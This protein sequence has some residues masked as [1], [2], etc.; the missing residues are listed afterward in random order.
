MSRLKRTEWVTIVAIIILLLALLPGGEWGHRRFKR[1]ILCR[2]VHIEHHYCGFTWEEDR[3]NACTEWFRRNV[4]ASHEHLWVGCST[5][6]SLQNLFGQNIGCASNLDYRPAELLTP[7]Q[8]LAVYEHIGN[9]NDSTQVFVEIRD[10]VLK[11]HPKGHCLASY[12]RDWVELDRF[13]TPWPEWSQKMDREIE[14]W[15]KQIEER[16]EN[17]K[18]RDRE[19]KPQ[20]EL[21]V[22]P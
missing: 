16:I 7:E 2:V 15:L 8:Q 14:E 6:Y 12:L 4:A 21:L 11:R 17:D 18:P 22:K 5:P 1:C 13:K 10:C 19:E 20:Q 9:V 3:E